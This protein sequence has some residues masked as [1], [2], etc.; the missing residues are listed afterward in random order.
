MT[1]MPFGARVVNA[2]STTDPWTV[3][4]LDPGVTTGWARFVTPN[5]RDGYTSGQIVNGVLGLWA[6]LRMA[7]FLDGMPDV[8]VC[9]SFQYRPKLDK[10]VLEPVEVI[11]AVKVFCYMNEIKLVMQTPAQRMWWTDDKL[12]RSQ[13]YKPGQPHANDAMRHLLTYLNV[14]PPKPSFSPSA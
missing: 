5:N 12:K 14:L 7:A 10:A 13:V 9:E 11:G 2:P 8:I 1:G 3:L 6:S 4:A